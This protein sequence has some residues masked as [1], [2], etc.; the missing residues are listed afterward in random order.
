MEQILCMKDK[1][2]LFGYNGNGDFDLFKIK[3]KY[4]KLIFSN[5]P[6]L[7]FTGLQIM[8]EKNINLVDKKVFSMNDIWNRLIIN[9]K[10]AGFEST[11][12]FYHLNTEEVYKRILNLK[13]KD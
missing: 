4:K 7:V 12:K 10:L 13:F 11:Q 9:N 5:T 1:N 8:D 6:N 3:S 2:E